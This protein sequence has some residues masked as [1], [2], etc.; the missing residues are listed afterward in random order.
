MRYIGPEIPKHLTLTCR[1]LSIELISVFYFYDIA[2]AG[3]GVERKKI[4]FILG[5]D[6][7][8]GLNLLFARQEYPVFFAVERGLEKMVE[9][10]DLNHS[11]PY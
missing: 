2:I 9:I 8:T 1:F 4:R 7:L 3:K 10:I 5:S 6:G 11:I